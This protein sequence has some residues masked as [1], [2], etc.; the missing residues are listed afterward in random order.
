MRERERERERESTA[1][2][3]IDWKVSLLSKK[4]AVQEER[5]DLQLILKY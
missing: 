2:D 3:G 4:N 1:N 5:V